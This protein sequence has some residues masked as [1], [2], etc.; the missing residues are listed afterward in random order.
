MSRAAPELDPQTLRRCLRIGGLEISAERAEALLPAV[1]ALL[2][3]CER[4]A[5]IELSCEG[6]IGPPGMSGD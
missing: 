6:G 4:V 2:A 1:A 3:A 5:A